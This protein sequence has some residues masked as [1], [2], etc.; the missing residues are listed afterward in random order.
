[1]LKPVQGSS[2]QEHFLKGICVEKIPY[3]TLAQQTEAI[4]PQLLDSVARV[5]KSGT[6]ILGP[7]V[8]KFEQA[9]AEFCGVKHAVGVSDGTSALY[10]VLEALDLKADD[11]VITAPNSFVASASAIVLAGAKPVFADVG[12]DLNLDPTKLEA[13]ITKKTKAIIPVHLTG[14]IAPMV[15]ILEIAKKHDLFVLEDA[16][17]AAGASLNGKR[18]GAWGHAASFS[19]HPLKNLRAFGDAG[20]ITTNDDKLAERLRIARNI[21]LKTRDN[22]TFWS[23]NDRLDEIQAAMLN[24][25]MPLF[26]KWTEERRKLAHRY[27]DAL[28]SVAKV[29][30]ENPGEYNVYQAYV[31]QVENRDQLFTH[32]NNNGIEAKIHYPIPIHLQECAKSLGYTDEMLPGT[33]YVTDRIISLPNYPGMTHSTQDRIISAIKEFYRR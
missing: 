31:L 14:R 24:V 15:Q 3:V 11:E 20:I 18:A 33:K 28:R 21:G 4:L 12:S 29:P 22:C 17:Q 1:M 13:A 10:L 30:D 16:A 27:S 19:L 8:Q 2:V 9:F 32:L 5:L 7:E 26:M 23:S 25:Q 6:Y